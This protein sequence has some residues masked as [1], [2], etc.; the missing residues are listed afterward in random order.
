MSQRVRHCRIQKQLSPS[1]SVSTKKFHAAEPYCYCP[2]EMQWDCLEPPATL[3]LK[4]PLAHFSQRGSSF[5]CA[6]EILKDFSKRPLA[7]STMH[8]HMAASGWFELGKFSLELPSWL[9][10]RLD[11]NSEI[12]SKEKYPGIIIT[13]FIFPSEKL[14]LFLGERKRKYSTQSREKARRNTP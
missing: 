9:I 2:H 4:H 14:P 10:S 7:R 12:I 3:Q 11:A 13:C 1:S 5:P 6:T 8:A